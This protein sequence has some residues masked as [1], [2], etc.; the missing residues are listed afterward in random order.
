MNIKNIIEACRAYGAYPYRNE[1]GSEVSDAQRNLQ[2]RT[3]Y[4]DD[5]TLHSFRARILRGRCS[6]NG[7][8]YLLQESLPHSDHSGRVRRNVLFDIFGTVVSERGVFHKAAARADVEFSEMAAAMDGDIY[9]AAIAA[10][11]RKRIESEMHAA[12]RTLALLDNEEGG[13]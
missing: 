6:S 3:H 5:D 8:Y 12:R 13:N 2:G 10:T 11:L 4:V 9:A 7:L 1:Y